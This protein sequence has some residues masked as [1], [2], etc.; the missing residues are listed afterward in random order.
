MK[1]VKFFLLFLILP[2]FI[3]G[4]LAAAPP[5]DGKVN[6]EFIN[7]FYEH[8]KKG[9]VVEAEIDEEARTLAWQG[10]DGYY[11]IYV[12]SDYASVKFANELREEYGVKV[13]YKGREASIWQ[14]ITSVALIVLI[15]LLVA[16]SLFGGRGGV[17]GEGGPGDTLSKM[18]KSGARLFSKEGKEKTTFE[19]VAGCEEAKEELKEIID[20]LKEPEKYAKLGGKIPKGVLLFGKPGT[21]KTLLAR[22]VAGEAGTPF[23][24]LAGSNFTQMYVGVGSARV[25]DLFDDAEKNA[26]CVIFI[27]EID[28]M[29]RR[30][31]S[32]DSQ[33]EERENT[34]TQ[35]LD[36]MDGFYQH[37]KP[38]IVIAATNRPEILD[39]AL[40]RPGRFTRHIP[41]DAPDVRGR[42]AILK[43]HVKN[44]PLAPDVKLPELAKG[45]PGFV[46]ADLANLINEAALH[47]VRYGKDKVWADD[48]EYAKDRVIMGLEKKILISEKE[49]KIIA[50]HEAGHAVAANN[51]ANADPVHKV[52]IVSRGMALGATQYL[53]KEDRRLHAKSYIIDQIV[54]LLAGRAA[55]K[56]IFGDE[57]ITNGAQNDI[58][59][60]TELAGKMVC[61]WGMSNLGPIAYGLRNQGTHSG[62]G[63]SLKNCSE[64]TASEIDEEVKDIIQTR[65][66][67]ANELLE[68]NK[69]ALETLAQAL[70]EKETLNAEDIEKIFEAVKNGHGGV[71]LG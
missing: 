5:I 67:L 11:R 21:G 44:I 32:G 65:M 45:T 12:S 61:E 56:M 70:L 66:N 34:L 28:A 49:R 9:N 1:V 22:A 7:E 53:P 3:A 38:I 31:S 48:F 13:K 24:S 39:E 71:I 58:E 15:I 35:I 14:A 19:D 69:K 29:G 4:Q 46:G 42:E 47:A 54:A 37:D 57:E 40:L 64:S 20:F 51:L 68:K 8:L 25:R 27:D 50:Y 30:R 62:G 36:K 33:N 17:V 10:K 60:A 26:P 16:F 63:S 41:V 43:I 52:T 6:V 23:L 55:E 18:F 2:F 59:R